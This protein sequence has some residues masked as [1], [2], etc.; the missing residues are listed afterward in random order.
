MPVIRFAARHEGMSDR[1]A[2]E[3]TP[4][5]FN[6]MPELELCEGARVLLTHILAVE[7]GLMN[8]TQGVVQQIVF[9]PG[10]GPD[11][12]REELRMPEAVV[13]DFP[14]YAGPRFYDDV[15][16]V[17]GEARAADAAAAAAAARRALRRRAAA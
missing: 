1:E 6:L 12:E 4:D 13:V 17:E 2:A 11:A 8:G 5:E 15:V 16:V 14:G 7:H 3:L 10:G 9:A